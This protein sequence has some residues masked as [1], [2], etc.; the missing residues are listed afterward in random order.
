MELTAG[1]DPDPFDLLAMAFCPFAE[2]DDFTIPA[3][4]YVLTFG[5]VPEGDL[6]L[7]P[8]VR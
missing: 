5:E 1:I 7:T 4:L 2:A 6:L 3:P 8:P